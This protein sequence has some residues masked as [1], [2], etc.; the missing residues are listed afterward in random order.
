MASE[1]ASPSACCA[2]EAGIRHSETSASGANK[3]HEVHRPGLYSRQRAPP[4][5]MRDRIDEHEVRR[6]E[7]VARAGVSSRVE[8]GEID[9]PDAGNI[10]PQNVRRRQRFE[11]AE[12]PRVD[13]SAET[14][15]AMFLDLVQ[16]VDG[17]AKID[18][19]DRPSP[20]ADQQR[21]QRQ[22]RD[23]R[24]HGAGNSMRGEPVLHRRRLRYRTGRRMV[25]L[26]RQAT[27][28]RRPVKPSPSEVVAL[29]P[30]R[31]TPTPAI[32]AMR[33]RI[34]SR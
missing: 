32:S 19:R 31:S 33:A 21:R 20:G 1:S 3:P 5:E 9:P 24:H 28:S 22:Q 25:A 30:T 26:A 2:G 13:E 7:A 23:R 34:A 10:D 15:A 29:T 8:R 27:P 16:H 17:Q 11:A 12:N 14:V 18:E 6:D 4:P